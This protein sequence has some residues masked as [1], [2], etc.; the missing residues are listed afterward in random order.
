MESRLAELD[1]SL[2]VWMMVAAQRAIGLHV[3]LVQATVQDNQHAVFV[4]L[5]GLLDSVLVA[6][7]VRSDPSYARV[8]VRDPASNLPGRKR[9]SSQGLIATA[10]RDLP[11]VGEAWALLSEMGGHFG[12]AAFQAS[13]KKERRPDGSVRVHV[14]PGPGWQDPAMKLTSLRHVTELTMLMAQLLANIMGVEA[15]VEV[16]E[17]Q[18]RNSDRDTSLGPF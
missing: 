10:K 15:A 3:A 13:I 14:S 8:V 7:Q 6:F 4:L 12:W 18:P 5:R 17:A 1:K 16:G 11:G 9:K 2:A